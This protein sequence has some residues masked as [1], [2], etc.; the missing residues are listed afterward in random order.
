[1]EEGKKEQDEKRITA[2]WLD[3]LQ[4]ESWQLELLISGFTVFLLL[5]ARDSI[6]ALE[7]DLLLLQQ[8]AESFFMLDTLYYGLRIAHLSLISCLLLH[9]A[10]R[11]VWIAAVG[12][13]SVSGD[14]D[15]ERFHFQARFDTWLRKSM[16][17]F[18]DYI[19]RLERYCSVLFTLAFLLVFCVLSIA[20]WMFF[21]LLVD[22]AFSWMTGD[23]SNSSTVDLFGIIALVSGAVYA[24][25]FIT[26]GRLKRIRWFS[27]PYFYFYRFM[28][29]LTLARFYRP[30]YYNLI[31]NR[32]GK[33]LAMSIPV[34]FILILVASSL[35]QIKYAYYPAFSQTGE[36]LVSNNRYDDSFIDPVSR[37]WSIS[38]ASKYVRNNYV[39][40]FVPYIPINDDSLIEYLSPEL[41]PSR[42]VGT[43]LEGT[44]NLGTQYNREADNAALLEALS[45][46][47]RIYVNDS[48]ME[49]KPRFH[50]HLER[51]QPGLLYLIPAH[52]LPNGEHKLRFD[53][54]QFNNDPESYNEGRVIYFYK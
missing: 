2:S 38:L 48:L 25:D 29:W 8:A 42:L 18:D 52:D 27:R 46:L 30:L 19:N 36:T 4:Q 17:P 31:D 20:S 54:K 28:G 39:E 51:E 53:R 24:L 47:R 5:G 50:R 23:Q 41:V 10:L 43:K 45:G 15:F 11:G 35:K 34:I 44:V 9:V 12:L 16:G 3:R 14:I 7:Y 1:M 22:N 32:F 37:A 40:A 26:L 13:R 6:F 33:K 49:L 21:W